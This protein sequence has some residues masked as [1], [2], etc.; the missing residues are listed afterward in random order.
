MLIF[1]VF[2]IDKDQVK[3]NDTIIP[4]PAHVS[5]TAW[6]AFWEKAFMQHEKEAGRDRY[7]WG[8]DF[9]LRGYR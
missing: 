4:R 3:L 9:H 5:V 2:D 7:T 6:L 8:N 1:S